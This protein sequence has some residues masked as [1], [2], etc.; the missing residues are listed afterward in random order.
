[1]GP[2][3]PGAVWVDTN[4]AI[5]GVWVPFG[6]DVLTSAS[7]GAALH[8]E[9]VNG[10]VLQDDPASDGYPSGQPYFES[11]DCSGEP[12]DTVRTTTEPFEQGFVHGTTVYSR[13]AT[14]T[15]R[16]IR[17]FMNFDMTVNSQADC[18]PYE[19]QPTIYVPPHGCCKPRSGSIS[20]LTAPD[21]A[22]DI[23]SFVPPFHVE[24]R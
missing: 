11:T 14:G 22:T 15:T 4:G 8:I 12:L 1:M 9:I 13:A 19:V 10:A 2:R 23:S 7:D 3:G 16:M 17:S 18:A 6:V 24:V 5:L 21:V 20:L